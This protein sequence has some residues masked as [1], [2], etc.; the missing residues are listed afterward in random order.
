MGS[1]YASMICTQ[2]QDTQSDMRRAADVKSY[3]ISSHTLKE[4]AQR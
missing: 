1:V 3:I 2:K 4:H